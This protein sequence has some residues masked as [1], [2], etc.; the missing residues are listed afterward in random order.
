MTFEFRGMRYNTVNP[1]IK[2]RTVLEGGNCAK[3]CT[4]GLFGE[5]IP[6]RS[7][8]RGGYA[9]RYNL[10]HARGLLLRD[11]Q[12]FAPCSYLKIEGEQGRPGCLLFFYES[13]DANA[14][15]PVGSFGFLR[16]RSRAQ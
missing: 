14:A 10:C 11:K 2:W 9:D 6:G 8:G 13:Q 3:A 5:D 7:F 15:E 4:T 16:L 1:K 12:N